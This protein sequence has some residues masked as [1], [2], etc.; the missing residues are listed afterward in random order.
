V[1]QQRDE[2]IV[3]LQGQVSELQASLGVAEERAAQAAAALPEQT[4]DA[5]VS[6]TTA[7]FQDR[8]KKLSTLDLLTGL[9]N[10]QH[11]M[12]LVEQA[13]SDADDSGDQA[14]LYI[15]LDDF[16]GIREQLG[17]TDSDMVLRDV[18]G[19]IQEHCGKQDSVARFGDY[20]FTIM[21]HG[22]GD[23]TT[24]E[25]AEGILNSL[26]NHAFEKGGHTVQLTTSI[27]ICEAGNHRLNAEDLVQRADLACEVARS[28]DDIKIHFHNVVVEERLSPEH[29]SATQET[30]RKT[31]EDAR[32]YLVYQPI[33]SLDGDMRERYEVL[34]RVL[35]ETGEVVLPSQFLEVAA[36][37]GMGG[38][39]DSWVI[40]NALRQLAEMQRCGRDTTF[41][42]KVS[43][44][45][46]ADAELAFWIDAKL[47][48]Y[49][50]QRENVVFEMA[51]TAVVDDMPGAMAFLTAMHSLQCKVALEHYGCS[52]QPQLLKRLPVDILKVNGSL[53]AGLGA[54]LENQ[55]RVKAIV[56][57]AR[58]LDMLC[59]AEHVEET[60]DLALL[61]QFGVQFVQGNFVQIPS[62][63]LDYNFEGDITGDEASI[64]GQSAG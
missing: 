17:V 35:D 38:V 51:E 64:F 37:M 50:L 7:M 9:A 48:E 40:D 14:L 56:E 45:T 49:Q 34:L 23:R 47:A 3:R 62:K 44:D 42:I 24:R 22:D 58:N 21:H 29:D 20:V 26:E 41:Y 63:E 54:N 19:I 53:I 15:L 12:Q 31:I 33:V 1:V 4:E 27:G 18:A 13:T 2:E 61:W 59:V 39:V 6:A 11:F 8:L 28:Q 10:R 43:A 52:S 32:F 36:S 46:I 16:R 55:I 30:V 5:E 57:L 60:G 25:F